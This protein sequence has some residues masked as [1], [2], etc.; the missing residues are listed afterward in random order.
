MRSIEA[1]VKEQEW[2]KAQLPKFDVEEK[3]IMGMGAAS[4][5]LFLLSLWV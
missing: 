2:F 3:F 4:L 5:V 1:K